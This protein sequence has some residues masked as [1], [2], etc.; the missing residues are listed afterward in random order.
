M[1]AERLHAVVAAASEELD[2]LSVVGNLNALLEGL[3]GLASQPNDATSQQHVSEARTALRNLQSAASNEWSAADRAVIEELGVAEAMGLSLV[4]RVEE[5][6]S[7]NEM[8]PSVAVSELTPV[9][10]RVREVHDQ[11]RSLDLALSF[12]GIGSDEPGGEAEI[13]FAIPREAVHE[14]LAELGQELN[15]LARILG[16]FQELATGTRGPIQVESISS[17]L[18][19]LELLAVPAFA[20]GV[21]RAVNE[22]LSVYKNV[23]EIREARQRLR[24]SGVPDEA[25]AGVE[26]HANQAIEDR[27]AALAAE[28]VDELAVA[29]LDEGRRNELIIELRLSLNAI[30]N[31]LDRGYSIDVRAPSP[32]ESPGGEGD[33]DQA[34]V[35]SDPAS[36]EFQRRIRDLAPRLRHE[37]PIGASILGLEEG[38]P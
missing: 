1:N 15:Y 2:E 17:S 18:F 23:L 8:T 25:L 12:F 24:E 26:Q 13:I 16:P 20:Y 5:V 38:E 36:A 21:A 3:Q 27:N 11:L 32:D 31:R 14:E 6:L 19:G 7:T 35:E 37:H 29:S 10:E 33:E 30:A 9:V 4:D 28:L 34:Q 22:I